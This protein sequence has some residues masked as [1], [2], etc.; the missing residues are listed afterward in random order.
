[1]SF[2]FQL[3]LYGIIGVIL[4]LAVLMLTGVISPFQKKVL[5]GSLVIWDISRD[6]SGVNDL[7]SEFEKTLFGVKI[8][9]VQKNPDTYEA[10]L[11][12]ALASGNSPDIF[13]LNTPI[14]LTHVNKIAPLSINDANAKD[15]LSEAPDVVLA[16]L[17]DSK[18]IYGIPWSID[19]LALYYNKDYLNSANI[20]RPP[21][22]WDEFQNDSEL[23]TKALPGGIIQRAGASFGTANNVTHAADILYA[24]L[25]QAG[26]PIYTPTDKAFHLTDTITMRGGEVNSPAASA[27]KFYTDFGN[28][29]SPLYSWN[30]TF[31]E[32]LGAFAAGRAAFYI[33]YA[34]DLPKILAK[35]PHLNFST[36]SLPQLNRGDHISYASYDF[37]T[38]SKFSHDPS[39]AWAVLASIYKDTTLKEVIDRMALPPA[40]RSLVQSAPPHPVLQPFYDQVLA[41]RSWPIPKNSSVISII[42]DMLESI[43]SGSLPLQE[44]LGRANAELETLAR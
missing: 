16:D 44:A 7:F 43:A 30:N 10:D 12:E 42:R 32:S 23:L 3:I 25:L 21:A 31:P 27:V 13:V 41:A 9:Y 19:T 4:I 36:A 5:S 28:Q 24:L 37:F 29:N 26:N 14:F 1:M 34:R 17:A 20:P 8:T 18:N 11:L 22:T 6:R 35:N 38:V 40:R 2:K 15:F 33:G 39:L